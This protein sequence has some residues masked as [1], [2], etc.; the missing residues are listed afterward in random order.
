[1]LEGDYREAASGVIEFRNISG[2]VLE[3][4]VQYFHFKHRYSNT[5]EDIPSFHID[6]EFAL[7]L[8]MAAH[9]LQA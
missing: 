7:D 6:P 4:V 2:A 3:R 1:M 5:V 9:Y 8:L